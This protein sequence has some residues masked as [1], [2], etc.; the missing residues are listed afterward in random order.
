M[1]LRDVVVILARPQEPGNVG[2]V[3]RVMKNMGL[4]TL[5]LV[6]PG[7]LDPG[8]LA[9]RAVHG[10]DIWER[11]EI[12]PSIP[13]ATADCSLVVGVTRRRGQRR[14]GVSL[15]PEALGS[16][17]RERS[18]KTAL[19]FGNERTGLEAEE[20]GFCHLAS[21]I[22]SDATFP[23]L[24]LSHAVQVYAYTLFRMLGSR[25]EVEGT[26]VPICQEELD[27]LVVSISDSL[28]ALGFYKHP[29]REE[30]EQFFRD[31]FA[32]AGLSHGE[33]EYIRT[34]FS[35]LPWRRSP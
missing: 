5:R 33:A 13:E 18:G 12:F 10:K 1:M 22:P 14:K 20:I 21:H 29:G 24:N 9:A 32:R 7:I 3:C 35:H 31:I 25:L 6:N 34:L 26:W 16:Y 11:T 28:A 2:A 4:G 30:Q 15:D 8:V 17:L 23:S 19:V 27:S